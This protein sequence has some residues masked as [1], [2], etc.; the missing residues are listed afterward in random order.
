MRNQSVLVKGALALIAVVALVA[1]G[2]CVSNAMKPKGVKAD[3]P[4]TA[5]AEATGRTR[6]VNDYVETGV[7]TTLARGEV[8]RFDAPDGSYVCWAVNQGA[9]RLSYHDAGARQR[10]DVSSVDEKHVALPKGHR[11]LKVEGLVPNTKFAYRV[12]F[13]TPCRDPSK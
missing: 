12:S 6:M 7:T 9:I 5:T 10:I 13:D 11:L 3:A 1:M 4:A 8:I 2:S